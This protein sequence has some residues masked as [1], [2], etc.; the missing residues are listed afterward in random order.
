MNVAL[1]GLGKAGLQIIRYVMT[2]PDLHVTMAFCRDGGKKADKT[3]SDVVP[4]KGLTSP[5]YEIGQAAE[6]FCRGEKPQVVIDF[7][8][9]EATLKMLPACARHGVNMVICTTNFSDGELALIKK[10]ALCHAGFAVAYAP[11]ITVGVNVLMML[12]E[13]TAAAL[14]AFDYAITEKHHNR[15]ADVSATANKIAAVLEEKTGRPVQ[16]NS[17]RAGGYVGLHEVLV[18]GDYERITLIHESFSRQA[19]A[20]GAFIAARYLEGR[21]GYFEMRDIVAHHLR[22]PERPD[23]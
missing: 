12:C 23:V 1:C 8:N 20:H 2:H 18:V 9:K 11:N 5:I 10:T 3:I 6:T 13:Q 19:F 17:I 4:F 16:V 15:K 14:P 7:S 22:R 21:E